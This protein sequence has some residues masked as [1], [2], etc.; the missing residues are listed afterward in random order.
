MTRATASVLAVALAAAAAGCSDAEQVLQ[1][2]A[3]GEF[4]RVASPFAG[5]L[6]QLAVKRGDTV[7]A[8]APLF[9]LEQANEAAARRE[10]S[11]RVAQAQAQLAN[12]QKAR[13]PT[14]IEAVRAQLGQAEAGLKLSAANLKRQQDLA[15]EHFTSGERLDDARAQLARDAARVDELRAQLATAKLAARPDEIRAAEAEAAAA[16]AAL[17]QA[18]W[19]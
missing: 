9:A 1:G 15:R 5:Q 11:D 18:D 13:R 10:A 3:E 2:Y 6:V 17:A 16:R 19:R 12:L 4:V 8:G 7:K 14:E